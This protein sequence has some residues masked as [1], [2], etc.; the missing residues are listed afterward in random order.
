MSSEAD[1]R[2]REP[3]YG[4]VFDVEAEAGRAELGLMLNEA[5]HNDPRRLLFV[6]SRYKFVAKMLQGAGRV[7]EVG[8]GDAFATRLVQQAVGTVTAVDFDEV[9]IEDARRRMH[10]KWPLDLRVHDI[11]QG[12]VQGTFEAAYTLDVIE[13]VPVEVEHRFLANIAA[14]LEPGGVLIVGSPSLESQVH[15]SPQSKAGHVNCK[16]GPALRDL[17][18]EHFQRAFL[19]S[20]NDEV[21]HTG[22]HPMANYQLVLAV[23]PRG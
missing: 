16:S 10:P 8:C 23:G 9:F 1:P 19:F 13:H 21:L 18:L 5:W 7:L 6:L 3:Q 2:T 15:A 22:F 14:S 11:A 20:M 17:L 12:P 4:L